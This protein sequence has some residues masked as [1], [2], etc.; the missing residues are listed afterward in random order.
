M[1]RSAF[2][3]I[4]VVLVL[5]LIAIWIYVLFVGSPE[6][7][8]TF[9]D[10]NFGDT[11]DPTYIPPEDDP[12]MDQPVV[13]VTA[14]E[15][16]RQLTTDPTIGYQE[17]RMSTSSDTLVYYAEAGTGHV[18]SIN[19]TTG[20]ERRISGTTIPTSQAAAFTPDGRYV[21]IQSGQGANSSLEVAELDG[22]DT[23]PTFTTIDE[24][25]VSFN[26]VV[27]DEFLYAVRTVNSTIG[28]R[29]NPET[30]TSE[31]LFTVPFRE[32][33]IVWAET[34]DGAHYVYP[35]ATSRLEGF[36][37]EVV[38]GQLERLPIDGYGL[39]AVGNDGYIVYSRLV[40]SEYKTFT[41]EKGTGLTTEASLVQ[42]PEKCT[43]SIDSDSILCANTLTDY[44]RNMP[45][46]W[47]MG[48]VG[49]TDGIW[50]VYP[51][52][53]SATLLIE[54]FSETGRELDMMGLNLS[55]DEA[56]LYFLNK[57]DRTL[58]LFERYPERRIPPPPP[59]ESNLDL[60]DEAELEL[61]E[62][63]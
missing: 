34:V 20:E 57:N 55:P 29:Y 38:D 59:E 35:K 5:V 54:S 49:F 44:D 45:D 47:Y 30:N 46:T 24:Q 17:V 11:S 41:Y 50:E 14:P 32:A 31:D 40:D 37:F 63:Q 12:V 58:W 23:N 10:F 25:V 53:Q 1:K 43:V 42:I 21:M 7:G 39:S 4:G 18:Y 61:N 8:G 22:S 52:T 60:S 2:I 19:L 13:D 26:G 56:N 6:N 9:A 15:R 48:E 28:K 27:G 16:L 33:I 36:L 51:N 3:I 62:T